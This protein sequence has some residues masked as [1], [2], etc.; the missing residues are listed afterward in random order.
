MLRRS[1]RVR[2]SPIPD[3]HEI[4]ILIEPEF[5]LGEDND[6]KPYTQALELIK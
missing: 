3:D 2:R 1:Q 5:D 4:V 6:P